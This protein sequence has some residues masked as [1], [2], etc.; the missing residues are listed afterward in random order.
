MKDGKWKNAKG[1]QALF[2]IL[3]LGIF[4]RNTKLHLSL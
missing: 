3:N 4:A 1:S 2:S